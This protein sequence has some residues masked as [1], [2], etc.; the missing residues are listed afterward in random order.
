LPSLAASAR[1]DSGRSSGDL[2]T[3]FHSVS[4]GSPARSTGTASQITAFVEELTVRR[5]VLASSSRTVALPL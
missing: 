1:T 2:S 4:I 5:G 3:Y